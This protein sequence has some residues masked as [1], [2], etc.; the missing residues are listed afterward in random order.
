MFDQFH[1]A[2]ARVQKKDFDAL[3]TSENLHGLTNVFSTLNL[4]KDEHGK[5]VF[6]ADSGPLQ[7]IFAR[8]NN[9]YS[10][11]KAATGKVLAD[12]FGK[13][14]YGW[15]FDIVR[16]FVLCLL[17][18]GMI[19][20]T[21]KGQTI[22]SARS[23]EAKNVFGNNNLF[24][25]ASF[26]P[27]KVPDF[28]E[29]VKASEA[30]RQTFGKEIAELEWGAVAYAIGEAISENEEPIREQEAVLKTNRLPG[31]E[32]LTDAVSHMRAIRSG[33]DENTILTFNGSYAEVKEAIKRAREL[34][35]TLIEPNL[36][37]LALARA[38]L[39]NQWSF[40]KDESDVSEELIAKAD[41]LGDL[42]KRETFFQQIPTIDQHTKAIQSTYIERFDVAVGKR[43]DVH[44]EAVKKLK[45]TAGWEQLEED[46]QERIAQPLTSRATKDVGTETPIPQLRA[47]IDACPKRLADAISQLL[48]VVEGSR[49]AE[50]NAS[51][52]FAD[53]VE[54]EE[55]LDNALS[56]LREE[57]IKLIGEDKKV[58]L[59]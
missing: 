7:E 17:R 2:A 50:V 32:V 40:L 56:G 6:E 22:E 26:R 51:S 19:D 8:I 34:E 20:A 43:A 47:D 35:Q 33:G 52:Y 1:M 54:T 21:S 59:K 5:P 36:H 23:V 4:I 55:Q 14:P 15:E 18:A 44:G 49:L 3:M 58:F 39:D 45:A 29:L 41:E 38:A 31:A 30:F 10:Y 42:L 57:C 12:E 46:Q 37:I 28:E 16:L 48:K 11:G 13:E 25:G 9:H 24:R 27:K 53:G